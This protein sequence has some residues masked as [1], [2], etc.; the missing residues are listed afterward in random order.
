MQ[1]L[2]NE[3]I[4]QIKEAFQSLMGMNGDIFKHEVLTTGMLCRASYEE[5]CENIQ[6]NS[7][8]SVS[9]HFGVVHWFYLRSLTLAILIIETEWSTFEKI[10]IDTMLFSLYNVGQHVTIQENYSLTTHNSYYSVLTQWFDYESHSDSLFV[11][12]Y[13]KGII[14]KKLWI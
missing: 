14:R 6:Y 13:T 11:V 10:Q 2:T 3:Q 5:V 1:T 4:T 9:E 7:Y 8:E 12:E